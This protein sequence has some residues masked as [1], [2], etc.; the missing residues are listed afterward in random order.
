LGNGAPDVF[1]TIVAV[2]KMHFDIAIGELTG[3]GVFVT[4]CVV[5]AVTLVN[6][7]QL[8]MEPIVRDISFYFVIASCMLGILFSKQF[9]LWESLL[10]LFFYV[11]YATDDRSA[12]PLAQR[13][14][15]GSMD[16]WIDLQQASICDW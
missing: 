11:W 12:M 4:C 13:S 5:G 7:A 3:A 10:L 6:Q 16:Q 9:S 1:S 14:I 15:D 2:N 8:E